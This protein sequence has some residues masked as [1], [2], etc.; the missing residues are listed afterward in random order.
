MTFTAAEKRAAAERE[1]KF[2]RRVYPRWIENGKMT[3]KEAD[4][5]IALMQAIADDYAEPDLF[6]ACPVFG[7]CPVCTPRMED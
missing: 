3:Q 2:R 5:Q 6:G 4:K 1:L 7:T